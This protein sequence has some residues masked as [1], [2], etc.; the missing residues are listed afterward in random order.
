MNIV[1]PMSL[2]RGAALVDYALWN[3]S[4]YPFGV[5]DFVGIV[6][7]Y[8]A[9]GHDPLDIEKD[10]GKR[11]NPQFGEF[12]SKTYDLFN[13][14]GLWSQGPACDDLRF[15][16]PALDKLYP[17]LGSVEIHRELMTAAAR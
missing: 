7:A 14:Q 3:G 17:K 13:N 12:A 4:H 1:E 5:A 15:V 9:K 16:H 8:M 6:A 11:L 2:A 10:L